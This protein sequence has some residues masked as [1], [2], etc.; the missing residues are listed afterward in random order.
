VE[1]RDNIHNFLLNELKLKFNLDKTIITNARDDKAHFLGMDISITPVSTKPLR[2]VSRGVYT[3]RMRSM[4]KLLLMAPIK[5]LVLKLTEK[6]FAK[7][8][9]TP[10]R[11]ARMI[12][13][14]TH[15]IVKHF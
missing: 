12:P 8:G 5:K 1:I 2:I 3:Y 4:T 14:E 11:F 6:G 13:F 9:G 10:T 15:Q 7:H